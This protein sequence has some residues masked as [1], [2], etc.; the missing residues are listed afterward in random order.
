MLFISMLVWS[1]PVM[2]EAFAGKCHHILVFKMKE[3]GMS[4]VQPHGLANRA[5]RSMLLE[6]LEEFQ[7]PWKCTT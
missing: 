3:L 2:A 5:T 4:K 6:A 1:T 7:Q